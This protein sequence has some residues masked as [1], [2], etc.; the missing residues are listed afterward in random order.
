M[1]QIGFL[2]TF[3][4]SPPF[5][6]IYNEKKKNVAFPDILIKKS[7]ASFV[8][9]TFRKSTFTELCLDHDSFAR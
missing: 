3:E 9:I 8:N 4:P 6:T 5:I 7:S 2:S 1:T